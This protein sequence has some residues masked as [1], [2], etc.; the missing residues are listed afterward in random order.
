LG[1]LRATGLLF[2]CSLG[3][4]GHRFRLALAPL[5]FFCAADRALPV[6]F[7]SLLCF[8]SVLRALLGFPPQLGIGFC[9][10]LCFLL[11]GFRRFGSGQRR[12][13]RLV[14]PLADSAE[15]GGEG[16][17]RTIGTE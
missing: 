1:P 16:G 14:E 11:G 13:D 12:F 10:C 5:G 17:D 2:R 15:S 4:R 8:L 6:P 7:G 9:L 3:S